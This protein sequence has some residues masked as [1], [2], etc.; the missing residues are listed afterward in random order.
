[1]SDGF[2]VD[3]AALAAHGRAVDALAERVRAAAAAGRPLDLDAYG[4]VGRV[5]AGSATEAAAAG[6]AAVGRL[7]ERVTAAA[8]GVTATREA[9]RRVEAGAAERFR[10][11]L[12]RPAR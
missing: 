9:Y 12:P 2:R 7:A 8:H 3:D 10:D 11:L 4:L 5:F 6:S 1:M